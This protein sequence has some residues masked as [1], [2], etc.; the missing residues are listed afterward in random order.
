[1]ARGPRRCQKLSAVWS[2]P[3]ARAPMCGASWWAAPLRRIRSEKAVSG[4]GA[5][6][7]S[8]FRR[9]LLW[10][11]EAG[12]L[13]TLLVS[14]PWQSFTAQFNFSCRCRSFHDVRTEAIDPARYRKC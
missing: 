6:K 1:M 10:D 7:N 2:D 4:D 12:D 14:S 3:E 13:A 8:P 11:L 9:K 5:F